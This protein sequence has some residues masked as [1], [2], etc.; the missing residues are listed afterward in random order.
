MTQQNKEQRSTFVGTMV[1]FGDGELV[2]RVTLGVKQTRMI[3]MQLQSLDGDLVRF[4][5]FDRQTPEDSESIGETML[6]TNREGTVWSVDYTTYTSNDGN[7]Y[8]TIRKAS[9][10]NSKPAS[11]H[12]TVQG[13]PVAQATPPPATPVDWTELL[14]PVG[15]SII[16][17]VAF[18]G[19]I[20][21]AE[22]PKDVYRLTD[23]YERIL[24]GKPLQDELDIEET[25]ED[26]FIEVAE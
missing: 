1:A 8:Y 18:K 14:D 25:E 3:N 15:K 6:R 2:H 17:Q 13:P 19:A 21:K 24:L 7:E 10:V 11:Q 5:T 4:A 22:D 16:R 23:A 9:A 26:L 12:N 20:Q